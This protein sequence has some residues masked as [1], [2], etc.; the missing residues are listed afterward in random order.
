MYKAGTLKEWTRESMMVDYRTR[1]SV[2]RWDS[3][4]S[5]KEGNDHHLPCR[6]ELSAGKQSAVA[7]ISQYH[8]GTVIRDPEQ[9][10]WASE[11]TDGEYCLSLRASGSL[12]T[13][14]SSIYMLGKVGTLTE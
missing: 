12:I 1:S 7:P 14:S 11:P 4:C 8:E 9:S 10:G 5:A 2:L 6:W 3:A 13:G